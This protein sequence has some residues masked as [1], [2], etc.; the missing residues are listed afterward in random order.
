MLQTLLSDTSKIWLHMYAYLFRYDYYCA[1]SRRKWG[2]NNY[3]FLLVFMGWTL[4]FYS[5]SE[6]FAKHVF[7]TSLLPIGK[8]EKPIT[9]IINGSEHHFE[10]NH[11]PIKAWMFWR[12][13]NGPSF[14]LGYEHRDIVTVPVATGGDAICSYAQT[15]G[16]EK[17]IRSEILKLFPNLDPKFTTDILISMAFKELFVDECLKDPRGYF[18]IVSYDSKVIINTNIKRLTKLFMWPHDLVFDVKK[19]PFFSFDEKCVQNGFYGTCF[20]NIDATTVPLISVY[21][22]IFAYAVAYSLGFSIVSFIAFKKEFLS[23]LR[24]MLLVNMTAATIG[25][26]YLVVALAVT[27]II[28]VSY[29]LFASIGIVPLLIFNL[30]RLYRLVAPNE[31]LAIKRVGVTIAGLLASWTICGIVFIPIVIGAVYFG[32]LIKELV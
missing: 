4:V 28:E 9:Y 18:F 27:S 29:V 20:N 32:G 3:S 26:V 14:H 6:M 2:K 10:G 12:D 22:I 11:R 17:D 23:N 16:A 1:L 25:V 15:G 21:V 13:V 31:E 24:T 19:E 5:A 30:S 8:E 7:H